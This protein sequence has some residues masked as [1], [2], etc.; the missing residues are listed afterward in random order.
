[1]ATLHGKGIWIVYSAHLDLALEMAEAI[2]ASHLLCKTGHR[3]MLFPNAIDRM[4]ARA[5]AAGLTP[6]AWQF[7]HCDDP[8]GEARAAIKTAEAGYEGIVFVLGD[9][10]AGQQ[11]GAEELGRRLLDARLNPQSLYYASFPDISRHPGIPH[12]EMQTFCQ[13]GFMPQCYPTLGKPAE[14]TIHKLTYEELDR[15]T[16]EQFQATPT[17][18]PI[19]AGYRDPEAADRLSPEAFA[20]WLDVL[21]EHAPAFFSVYHAAATDPALWPVLGRVTLPRPPAPTGAEAGLFAPPAPTPEEPSLGPPPQPEEDAVYVTVQPDDTVA[22]LCREYGC[23]RSQFW[24]WNGHLWDEQ[25]LPRDPDYMQTGWQ[26]RV[27]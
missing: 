7:I 4:Q 2:E 16:R 19:L 9:Q 15:W 17:V 13:G 22:R 14:V 11:A 1:M 27:Q 24:D 6:L 21:A 20:H 3:A 18:Y 26:I 10:A 12:A 5:R 23:T 8:A 25:W